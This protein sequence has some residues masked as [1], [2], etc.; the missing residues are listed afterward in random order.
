MGRIQEAIPVM[1]RIWEFSADA[2]SGRDVMLKADVDLHDRL[3]KRIQE[4]SLTV[5]DVVSR[6]DL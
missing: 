4:G 3:L 6:N 2:V 5:G 1:K